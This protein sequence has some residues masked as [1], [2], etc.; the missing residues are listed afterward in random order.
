MK[1]VNVFLFCVLF[2]SALVGQALPESKGAHSLTTK[3]GARLSG[4]FVK[5]EGGSIVLKDLDAGEVKIP[6]DNIMDFRFREGFSVFY[7]TTKRSDVQ[8]GMLQAANG[9]LQVDGKDFSPGDYY[10]FQKGEY[11]LWSYTGGLYSTLS[12]ADGNSDQLSYGFNADLK[13][14]H[15]EHIFILGSSATFAETS[16][17]RSAQRA[18]GT[19]EYQFM[20][21]EYLGAFFRETLLHDD[22]RDLRISSNTVI[23]LTSPVLAEDGAYEVNVNAG[24]TFTTENYKTSQDK[25]F[26]GVTLGLN[27]KWSLNKMV[28]VV[29]G[30]T[31][32]ASLEQT[33][34]SMINS[35]IRMNFDILDGLS[36]S[37]L[38]EHDYDNLPPS[39]FD[40]QDIRLVFLVGWGF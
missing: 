16:G 7:Q 14:E 27:G 39:G 33:K 5:S 11:D 38:F 19:F 17:V 15:P 37:V 3:N 35:H 1:N 31:L 34:D 4:E 40:R 13:I 36:T 32:T 26:G 30:S 10:R 6:F 24:V 23:G 20:F 8:K 9:R 29:A 2:A 12:I 18:L 21:L 25:E 28:D 22:F